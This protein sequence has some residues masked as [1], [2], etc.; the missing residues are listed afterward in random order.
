M[1]DIIQQIDQHLLYFI[2]DITQCSFLDKAM[3]LITSLGNGGAFWILLALILLL[4][5]DTRKS[6]LAMG[7]AMLLCFLFG[8]IWLKNFIAR[9]RPYTVDPSIALLI[10]PSSEPYSFPSGH[11]MNAFSAAFALMLREEDHWRAAVL[12]AELIAFS[13]IYLMM[14][15][16]LDIVGG[17]IVAYAAAYI[18]NC[19]ITYLEN[20]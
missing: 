4:R 5:R 19:C 12:L 15:Y 9:P 17:V 20:R 1:T 13:R 2:H 18:V 14:H 16:P 10:K 3:P 8:N 11:T 7:A 6:G